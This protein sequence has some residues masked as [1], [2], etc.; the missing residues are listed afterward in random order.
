[1][2]NT[3]FRS[4]HEPAFESWFG[5][6]TKILKTKSDFDGMHITQQMRCFV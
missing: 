3:D 5:F 4:V 6:P 1:M 2:E